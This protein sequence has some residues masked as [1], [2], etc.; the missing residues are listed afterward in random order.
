MESEN[1]IPPRLPESAAARQWRSALGYV[2]AGACLAWVVYHIHPKHLVQG[3]SQLRWPFVVLGIASDNFGYVLQGLRWR[4]LLKPV[5]RVRIKRT[6]QGIFIAVF[7]SDVFPLRFGEIA[8]AYLMSRWTSISVAEIIPSMVV[9][10]MFDGFWLAAGIGFVT[11]FLPLP[12][13]LRTGAQ[14]FAGTIGAL[15]ILFIYSVLREER[16]IEAGVW[17][18]HRRLFRKISYFIDEVAIGLQKIGFSAT[19]YVAL[20]V[21]FAALALQALGVWLLIHAYGLPLT[22]L[23]G[24]IVFLVIR[25]GIVVPSAPANLGTYQFFAALGLQLLG[26]D[27]GVAGGFSFVLFFVLS[28]PVWAFGF[29]ALSRTRVGLFRLRREAAEAVK[30]RP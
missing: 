14:I 29:Y 11:L 10:R 5:A 16:E 28:L 25:V 7:T 27:S 15:V 19:F 18:R 24:V 17:K 22:L 21:S 3:I 12:A 13:Y 8:R 1:G 20:A 9:E 2:L 6:I 26:I 4:L 30:D 23:E